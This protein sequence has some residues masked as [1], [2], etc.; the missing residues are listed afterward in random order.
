M[1]NVYSTRKTIESAIVALN[2][3]GDKFTFTP[4]QPVDI[5]RWGIVPTTLLDL[6]VGFTGALDFRPTAGSDASRVN[7]SVAGGVDTAGGTITRT[8]D[9][10]LGAGVYHNLSS[11]LEVDPGEEVVF[12]VTDAADTSGDGVIFIEYFEKPF[13]GDSNRTI[14]DPA[15]RIGNMILVAS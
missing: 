10:A 6:G 9:V 11:P 5:I 12:E 14:G 15:N 3:T 4:G 2:S 7:G 13:V 8:A 1:P